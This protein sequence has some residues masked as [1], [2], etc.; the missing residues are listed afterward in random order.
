MSG[1]WKTMTDNMPDAHMAKPVSTCQHVDST[2]L[3]TVS[4]CLQ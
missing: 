2:V 3:T 4:N 1:V